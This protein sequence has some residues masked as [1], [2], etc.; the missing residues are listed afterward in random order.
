MNSNI[1]E[2]IKTTKKIKNKERNTLREKND[3]LKKIKK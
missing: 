3:T 1:N 2:K